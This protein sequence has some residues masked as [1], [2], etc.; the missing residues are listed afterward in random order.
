MMLQRCGTLVVCLATACL[1]T[2]ARAESHTDA[3]LAR[4]TTLDGVLHRALAESPFLGEATARA[5]AARVRVDASGRRPDPELSWEQ[6]SVPLVEPWALGH[7]SMLMLGV[8]QTFP[9]LGSLDAERRAAEGAARAGESDR[10]TRALDLALQVKRAFATFSRTGDEL[11]IRREHLELTERLTELARVQYGASRLSQEEVLRAGA[12]ASRVAAELA[13]AEQE[14]RSA[15]ALLNT[16]MGRAVDAPLGPPSVGANTPFDAGEL[17]TGLDARRPELAAAE[18]AIERDTALA[19]AARARSRWPMLMVGV[20]L[21]YDPMRPT[22]G[23]SAM[24]GM[25]L[26]WLN[27]GRDAPVRAAGAELE[28]QKQALVAARLNARYELA[29]ATAR[30]DAARRTLA[31]LDERVLPEVRRGFDAARASF[32]AGSGSALGVIDSLRTL[33][34]TRIDRIRAAWRVATSVADLERA[35]GLPVPT[36]PSPR[37]SP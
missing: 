2:S 10:Q 28:A 6:W 8:R 30:V 12:E 19:D 32:V 7:A 4:T 36:P 31:A 25:S 15:I 16:L 3:E 13:M 26:P 35:A 29:D 24:V 21:V 18:S 33:L 27:P 17:E 20:D 23:Y 5:E 9:A 11:R 22:P 14:R 34:Q 37:T 1:A